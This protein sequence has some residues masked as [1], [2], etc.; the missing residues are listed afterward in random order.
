MASLLGMHYIIMQT[1][2]YWLLILLSL[3]SCSI[4]Y[5][6]YYLHE[7]LDV[8]IDYYMLHPPFYIISNF[9]HLLWA[10]YSMVLLHKAYGCFHHP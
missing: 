5:L 7:I 9:Q 6:H 3:L 8:D 10:A 2:P 4:Q 1:R